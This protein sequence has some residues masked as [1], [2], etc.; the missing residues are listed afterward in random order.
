[1]ETKQSNIII[2]HLTQ[3]RIA[4]RLTKVFLL[5]LVVVVVSLQITDTGSDSF[6]YKQRNKRQGSI[7]NTDRDT[8]LMLLP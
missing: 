3:T 4:C 5:A 1:L 2:A 6:Y 7:T 8:T